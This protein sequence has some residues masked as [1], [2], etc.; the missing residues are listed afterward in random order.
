MAT[1]PPP[2]IVAIERDACVF[3]WRE[4][5]RILRDPASMLT[6]ALLAEI[7][8]AASQR[9]AE[10]SNYEAKRGKQ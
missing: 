7:A 2:R 5:P 4:A 9:I 8:A 3:P 10:R 6:T 1:P